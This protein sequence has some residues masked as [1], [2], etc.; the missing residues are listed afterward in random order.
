MGN[1]K[2]KIPVR[3][4]KIGLSILCGFL[5]LV[6]ILMT[7]ATVYVNRL[8]NKIN[9]V[10]VGDGYSEY[11]QLSIPEESHEGEITGP[12]VHET[13]VTINTNPGMPS[14]TERQGIVNILLVGQDRLPGQ[15]RQRSDSMILVSFN[16]N[17][18][19]ITMVSFLRDSYVH[20]PGKAP[21]KLN[22]AYAFGGF[23]L[24]NE[25]LA[26]NFGVHVDANVEVDFDGFEGIINL[27][28]GVDISLTE[29][30][31]NYMNNSWGFSVTPGM[32]HMD[33]HTA[34]FYSRIRMID[35][36]AH[37]ANRQRTVLTALI[38]KYKSKGIT[39]MLGILEEILPL[40]TTDMN[41]DEIVGY[42]WDLFPML[43]TSTIGSQQ[44][45]AT[46]T[47]ENMNVG[48]VTSTKV[49]DMEANIAIL[50][51]ILRN[52]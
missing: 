20:I 49:M 8:L 48:N 22:A 41:N 42:L 38:N 46:G 29:K 27:L 30:E 7:F 47:Y 26:V 10:P 2:K 19:N 43:S 18:N 51:S 32:N 23:K 44:I 11:T 35:S 14:E 50:N 28:G 15:G 25:T 39:E 40:I 6:L 3:W 52:P 24:L 4:Q 12:S 37:R 16:T 33:G 34:L 17:T 5:A 13:D 21:Q 31:A 1:N 45:P 9:R 36:D